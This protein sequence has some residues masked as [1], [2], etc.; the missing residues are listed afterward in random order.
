MTPFSSPRSVLVMENV[1]THH[2]PYVKELYR[3]ARVIIEYLPPYSPDYSPI[4][5]SFAVLKAWMRRNKALA[6][7][8]KGC[9]HLFL[10]IAVAQ[11]NFKKSAR[12]F[13]E[14]CGIVISDEDEDIDYDELVV[15]ENLI[16]LR[17]VGEVESNSVD[18]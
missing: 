13:F 15:E 18:C 5:E 8:L 14:S 1:A 3:Q 16:E 7:P 2:S 10:H 17:G 12:G 11:C 4:E 6:E 9:F